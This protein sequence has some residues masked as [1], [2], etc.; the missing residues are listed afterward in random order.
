VSAAQALAIIV[1]PVP[2]GPNIRTPLG[3]RI[4]M[5]SNKCLWVI[6]KTIASLNSSIYLS[7]PPTSVYFS[8]GLS[9]TSIA[10]TIENKKIQYFLLNNNEIHDFLKI[11]IITSIYLYY[12]IQQ[13]ISQELGKNPYWLLQYHQV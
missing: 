10:F 9:S 2:G 11:I 6:G 3:G 1:L 5:L 8:V 4:P 7:S 13:V 12:H